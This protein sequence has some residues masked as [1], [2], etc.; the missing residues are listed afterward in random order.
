MTAHPDQAPSSR[1]DL[2]EIRTELDELTTQ[3]LQELKVTQALRQQPVGCAVQL[4]LATESGV[5]VDRLNT[6][7]RQ[8]LAT[9]TQS[10][11]ARLS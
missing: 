2:G 10:A 7:H 11:C 1:P 5:V 3:F 9:A 4:A 8:A 6:L